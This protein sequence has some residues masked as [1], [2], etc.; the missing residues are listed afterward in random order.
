MAY[1][2]YDTMVF[3]V[4]QLPAGS[5]SRNTRSPDVLADMMFQISYRI[6][7]KRDDDSEAG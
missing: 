6:L 2:D 7:C 5:I 4:I 1:I 3:I